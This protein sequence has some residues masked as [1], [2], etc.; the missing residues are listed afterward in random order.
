MIFLL[1]LFYRQFAGYGGDYDYCITDIVTSMKTGWEFTV[2]SS[3]TFRFFIREGDHDK[4]PASL[5]RCGRSHL[6]TKP[7]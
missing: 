3:Y 5:L 4:D 1:P 2:A 6:K 7:N